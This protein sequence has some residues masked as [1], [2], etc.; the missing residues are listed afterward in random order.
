MTDPTHTPD[1]DFDTAWARCAP[2]LQAALD[3]DPSHTLDQVKHLCQVDPAHIHF[4]P[5]EHAAV[6]T[7]IADFPEYRALNFWLAGGSFAEM[8]VG[9]GGAEAFARACGCHRMT[10]LSRLGMIKRMAPLGYRPLYVKMLKE[11]T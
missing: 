10:S 1:E 4:W 6:V 7:E 2:W 8:A 5:G 9:H 11:L 3:R